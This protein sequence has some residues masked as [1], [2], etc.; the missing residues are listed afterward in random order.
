M[1][2]PVDIDSV[3]KEAFATKD[4][5]CVP[6]LPV[7]DRL[8]RGEDRDLLLDAFGQPGQALLEHCYERIVLPGE[9]MEYKYSEEFSAKRQVWTQELLKRARVYALLGGIIYH[10]FSIGLPFV[11]FWWVP[12][13]FRDTPWWYSVAQLI[14]IILVTSCFYLLPAAESKRLQEKVYGIPP[15]KLDRHTLL[16][17]LAGAACVGLLAYV[18]FGH[19][20]SEWQWIFPV[21]ISLACL[22]AIFWLVNTHR[23]LR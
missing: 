3:D 14:L 22:R 4:F 10:S 16:S 15:S 7:C 21:L 23:A 20:W 13:L 11:V 19:G 5:L 12:M 8:W 17:G 2:G 18:V 9:G 1:Y 6:A